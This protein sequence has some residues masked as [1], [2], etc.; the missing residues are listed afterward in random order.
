[1]TPED[2]ISHLEIACDQLRH[3]VLRSIDLTMA[4]SRLID[5]Q[6]KHTHDLI[7][8]D[9]KQATA[10]IRALASLDRSL[11]KPDSEGS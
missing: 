1:M 11:A 5:V 6:D 7:S 9:I 8:R 3:A 2:R 10:E 4:V